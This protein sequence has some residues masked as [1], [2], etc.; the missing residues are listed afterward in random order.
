VIDNLLEAFKKSYEEYGDDFISDQ[1]KLDE[2]LYI[3]ISPEGI[4]ESHI[5][6]KDNENDSVDEIYKWFQKRDFISKYLESN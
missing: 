6:R 4:I 5:I 2:G 1:H 3:K